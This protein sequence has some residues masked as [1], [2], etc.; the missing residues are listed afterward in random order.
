M[1]ET[2]VASGKIFAIETDFGL[3]IVPWH[4]HSRFRLIGPIGIYLRGLP[5]CSQRDNAQ[6][7]LSKN[8]SLVEK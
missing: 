4:D 1:N 3:E 5:V 8:F 6:T 7:Q 2:V